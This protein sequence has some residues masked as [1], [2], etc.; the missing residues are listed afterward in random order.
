LSEQLK[1]EIK[2]QINKKII[3]N[4]DLFTTNFS[5]QTTDKLI[6]S[7]EQ[8]KLAPSEVVFEEDTNTDLSFYYI[9]KGRGDKIKQLKNKKL[10]KIKENNSILFIFI[11]LVYL[12]ILFLNYLVDLCLNQK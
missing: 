10:N 6:F 11:L 1:Y 12:F 8:I 9:L 2:M 7:L 4:F 3:K 5:A